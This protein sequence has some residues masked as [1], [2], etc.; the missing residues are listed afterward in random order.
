MIQDAFRTA[1]LKVSL[2]FYSLALVFALTLGSS[3]ASPLSFQEDRAQGGMVVSSHS[4]ATQSGLEVLQGGGNAFDAAIAVQMALNVTE[5]MMSGIG[6][7]AFFL[8]YQAKTQRVFVIDARERAPKSARPD[9]FLDEKGRPIPFEKRHT[10][11]QAV[12]VPGT[13]KGLVLM[14]EKLGSKPWEELIQ[15]AIR[16]AERGFCVGKTFERYASL[17]KEKLCQE[18]PKGLFCPRGRTLRKGER[19]VQKELGRTL[20]RIQNEKDAALYKGELA[21]SIVASVQERGGGMT[22][23]DLKSAEARMAL[24]LWGQYRGYRIATV[25]PPSGGGLAVLEAL[26]ILE[27]FDMGSLPLRSFKKY[28]TFALALRIVLADRDRYVGDPEFVHVPVGRMLSRNHIARG[29]AL[30][31]ERV[32]NPGP[33]PKDSKPW[34]ETTHFAV[35]DSFGNIACVTSTIEQPFGSGIYLKD[36][37]F[38]LNNELTDFDPLPGGPNEPSP[39][40]APMSSMAPTIVF[41]ENFPILALGSPGGGTI[42]ASVLETLVHSL[43]YGLGLKEAIEEPRVFMDSSGILIYEE[44]L[45]KE[46]LEAL[47]GFVCGRVQG[48]RDIGNVQAIAFDPQSKTYEGVCDSTREGRAAGIPRPKNAKKTAK[49]EVELESFP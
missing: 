4:L 16:I 32:V 20:L 12:G 41:K 28:A 17:E 8:L 34:G 48:P 47:E 23:E 22:L 36:Y 46:A 27:G 11:G 1:T 21:R 33:R 38:F 45:S 43:D 18:G 9:M 42:I 3:Y 44:G 7:G 29:R 39:K 37:G 49:F 24:P 26:G 30:I 35:A 40:K 25:A 2:V 14:H 5:P 15:P 10:L 31:E 13:L 6:G 19:L